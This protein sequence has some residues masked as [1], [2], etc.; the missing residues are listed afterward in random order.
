MAPK[1]YNGD[2]IT[3]YRITALVPIS[4]IDDDSA[5]DN[6]AMASSHDTMPDEGQ[7]PVW[8]SHFYSNYYFLLYF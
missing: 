6:I 7:L 1:M 5:L 4:R 3:Q 2:G 8:W